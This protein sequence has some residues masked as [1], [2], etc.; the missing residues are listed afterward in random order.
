LSYLG[1]ELYGLWMAIAALTAMAAFADLGLGNGLMTKLAPC[2]TNADTNTARRYI[3]NAYM[4][5]TATAMVLC[6]FLWTASEFVSWASLFNVSSTVAE[7]DVR[8]L[9][10][11]CL[12]AFLINIPLSLVI[13]VQ[14]AYQQ[15]TQSNLWQAFGSLLT[16]LLTVVAVQARL[17]PL[18]LVFATLA[19]PLLSNMINSLWFYIW[20]EPQLAP[21]LRH[22]DRLLA[23]RLLRLSGLFFL[24]TIVMSMATN[25]DTLLIAYTL[26]LPTVTAFAVPSRLFAQLG[27]LISVINLPLWPANAAAL[28]RGD[29]QWVR[30]ITL[31]MTIISTTVA[32]SACGLLVTLGDQ[33]LSAWLGNSLE[34]DRWL[35][36]GLAAW[37]TV[38]AALSPCFMVQN[39]AGIVRPQLLGW[40]VYLIVSIPL[41]WFGAEHLGIAAVPF[42]GA[43]TYA[44]TVLPSALYGYR[45]AL[46]TT[47]L[48]NLSHER[49]P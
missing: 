3:S 35:L 17:P 9:T 39:A 27:L 18:V 12:T 45:K 26:G 36:G 43:T 49:A 24:L 20:Q 42:I 5:L 15:V 25:A 10:L 16:L 40:L 33:L 29:A 14:Y 44:L 22:V 13:R 7:T 21:T 4:T 46:S 30:R 1:V 11:T 37:W 41:K 34:A 23:L 6:I 38:L 28:V 2:Y 48:R 31:R 19:G 32:V 47:T 8:S